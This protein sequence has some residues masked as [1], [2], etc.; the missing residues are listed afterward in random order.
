[1]ANIHGH[2]LTVEQ[3]GGFTDG[4]MMAD[5]TNVDSGMDVSTDGMY[6]A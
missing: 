1:M 5:D 2:G 3:L 4:T 6:D